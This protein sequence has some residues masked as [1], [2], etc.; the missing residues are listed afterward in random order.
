MAALLCGNLAKNRFC[1]EVGKIKQAQLLTV[2]SLV[3]FSKRGNIF[4]RAHSLFQH[5]WRSKSAKA[6]ET[7]HIALIQNA[8]Y[9]LFLLNYSQLFE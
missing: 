3:V 5:I 6:C 2:S 9:S 1:L 7:I 4:C 8:S